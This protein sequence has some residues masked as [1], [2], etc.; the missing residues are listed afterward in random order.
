MAQ[1]AEEIIAVLTKEPKA[2]VSVTLEIQAKFQSSASEQTKRA[3][4]ETA[5]ALNFKNADW[6]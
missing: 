6:E 5:R 3:V 2:E 4:K 1:V